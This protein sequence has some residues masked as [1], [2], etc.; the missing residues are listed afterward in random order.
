MQIVGTRMVR[1]LNLFLS[2]VLILGLVVQNTI[3]YASGGSLT[4]FGWQPD[5]NGS[6]ISTVAASKIIP[7]STSLSIRDNGDAN[8]NLGITDAGLLTIRNKITTS[9]IDATAILVNSADTGSFGI[10]GGTT[11]AQSGANGAVLQLQGGTHTGGVAGYALLYGGA[12]STGSVYIGITH[13]S[14][15]INFQG[16]GGTMISMN[17]SGQLTT[18]TSFGNDLGWSIQAAANQA[19]NT[20][21]STAC[22]FGF[23]TALGGTDLVSCTDATADRCLCAGGS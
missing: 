9:G 11:V 16:T 8:T 6:W 14:A 10:G 20:T 2:F 5:G 1:R 21:C 18:K 15:N 19:C 12:Q 23:D 4:F 22:V 17:N 3:A 13:A 7:G